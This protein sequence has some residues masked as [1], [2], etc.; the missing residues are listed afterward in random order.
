MNNFNGHTCIRFVFEGYVFCCDWEAYGTNLILLPDKRVI[1]VHNWTLGIPP[2]PEEFS[3]R[4]GIA[5]HPNAVPAY[6]EGPDHSNGKPVE[7]IP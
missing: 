6:V 1:E 7:V 4:F 3:M 2:T 5:D